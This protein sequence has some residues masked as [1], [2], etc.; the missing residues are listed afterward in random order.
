MSGLPTAWSVVGTL[1]LIECVDK[2][3]GGRVR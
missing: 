2:G 1:E 3:G